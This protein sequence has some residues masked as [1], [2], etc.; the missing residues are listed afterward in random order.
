MEKILLATGIVAITFIS[1][2]FSQA[3]PVKKDNTIKEVVSPAAIIPVEAIGDTIPRAKKVTVDKSRTVIVISDDGKKYKMV[4][5]DGKVTELYIDGK[6]I[7]SEEIES[8]KA[9]I[10]M[11]KAEYIKSQKQLR[12][13]ADQLKLEQLELEE[14]QKELQRQM[15]ELKERQE[16]LGQESATEQEKISKQTEKFNEDQE[17]LIRK[18][19]KLRKT[20]EKTT[21]KTIENRVSVGVNDS[22]SDI[23]T[24]VPSVEKLTVT[25]PIITLDKPETE[26]TVPTAP[27]VGTSK[28]IKSIINDL[29]A[30]KLINKADDDLS[31]S[32]NYEE[33]IV[34]N[35]RQ[36]D[37][38]HE[39]FVEKYIKG[40]HNNHIIYSHT[41]NSTHTESIVDN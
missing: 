26:P 21:S 31:F 16:Q 11:I 24:E 35:V 40:D 1:A 14:Q 7:P 36:P 37:A 28:S 38:L 29:L 20:A 10:A 3:S 34:N 22:L 6:K 23:I 9:E 18:L 33:L 13:Q 17:K 25:D 32:L 39:K 15:I 30:E 5:L 8:H 4:E 12:D 41:K 2:T 19:E 27:L